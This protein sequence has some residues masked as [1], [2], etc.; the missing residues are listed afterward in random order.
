MQ[1]QDIVSTTNYFGRILGQYPRDP[2]VAHMMER[3]Q[4]EVASVIFDL[5]MAHLKQTDAEY[6]ACVEAKA[7]PFIAKLEPLL[8]KMKWICGDKLT[9]VDFWAGA[10]YCDKAANPVNKNANH[11]ACWATVLQKYPNFKRFGEDFKAANA[12]WLNKRTD[13][14]T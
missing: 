9:V 5:S 2:E 1:L 6:K 7:V 14:P 4:T 11:T 13:L 3:L 8:A 12:D 10:L